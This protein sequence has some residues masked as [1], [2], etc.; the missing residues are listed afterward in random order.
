MAYFANKPRIGQMDPGYL[1]M[2]PPTPPPKRITQELI[3]GA[4][5]DMAKYNHALEQ[6]MALAPLC[7]TCGQSAVLCDICEDCK[8]CADGGC[9]CEELDKSMDEDMGIEG[10]G[11]Y[12]NQ[13]QH[14][15]IFDE[16]F[17]EDVEV[18]YYH[19]LECNETWWQDEAKMDEAKDG[20]KDAEK[21][22]HEDE[23]EFVYFQI[24][25][26]QWSVPMSGKA[27]RALAVKLDKIVARSEAVHSVTVNDY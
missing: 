19:T 4:K 22:V 15:T 27:K 20:A 26:Q 6:E 12:A 10:T 11:I 14:R 16:D 25:G 17:E 5:K 2:R 3:K 7:E 23:Y 13:E 1:K 24:D 9:I 18:S 21:E 8:K